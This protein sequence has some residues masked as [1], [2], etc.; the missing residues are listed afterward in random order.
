MTNRVRFALISVMATLT[1][2]GCAG[3][4][5]H[6]HGDGTAS[7]TQRP[8][9]TLRVGLTEWA[10]EKSAAHLRP[11]RVTL[12]VTNAGATEH[13]LYITDGRH[14]WHTPNLDPGARARLQISAPP[15]THFRL[16]CDMP[17]HAAQGMRTTISATGAAINRRR[18][19]PR[20]AGT[21][22]G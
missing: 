5:A 1:L 8:V 22:S 20:A 14:T 3:T 13:N 6:E 9:S 18:A 7:V 11:G 4:P 10:I 17:G 2:S 15:G 21:G 12:L 19:G 16:W